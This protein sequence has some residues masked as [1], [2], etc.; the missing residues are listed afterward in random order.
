MLTATYSLVAISAEQDKA[1]KMLS[2]L[3]QHLQSAWKSLPQIQIDFAFLDS[4][5]HRLSQLDNYFR[6]RKIELYLMPALRAMGR[7]AQALM[8]ELD[9]LSARAA[10]LLGAIGE[11]LRGMFDARP[12]NLDEV[13]VAMDGY[14]ENL[15]RRLEWENNELL[16]LARRL[17]SVEDWFSIAAQMLADDGNS[18]GRRQRAFVPARGA[19]TAAQAL[20]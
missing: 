10:A 8:G 9:A 13:R 7:E 1:H 4:A 17:L 16:P 19:S 3:R 5:Y 12:R 2:R 6:R 14:C 18:H 20:R 15:S 11:Q